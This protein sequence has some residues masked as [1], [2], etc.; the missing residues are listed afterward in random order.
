MKIAKQERTNTA[1]LDGCQDS[2]R[3]QSDLPVCK[4]IV[5]GQES[6][7]IV[8]IAGGWIYHQNGRWSANFSKTSTRTCKLK[9]EN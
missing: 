7:S 3:I 9:R 6:I 1:T 8:T 2:K 5:I 4:Y